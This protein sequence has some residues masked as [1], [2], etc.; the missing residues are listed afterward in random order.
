MTC[1]KSRLKCTR[2]LHFTFKLIFEEIKALEFDTFPKWFGNLT[3]QQKWLSKH[4]GKKLHGRLHMPTRMLDSRLSHLSSIQFPSDSG[5]WP[6]TKNALEKLE[7]KVCTD[8]LLQF[9]FKLIFVEPKRR[10]ISAIPNWIWN[11]SCQ[12][13]D[14]EKNRGRGAP[15]Y[16]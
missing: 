7:A 4:R 13:R 2:I 12:K 15:F 1:K 3:C 8:K 16:L 5:I 6:V 9:T 14:L 11:F 10:Q